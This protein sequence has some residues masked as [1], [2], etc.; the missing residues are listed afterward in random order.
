MIKLNA[1]FSSKQ[2]ISNCLEIKKNPD[3][4]FNI[5]N[6]MLINILGFHF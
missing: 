3:T 1:L 4:V 5:Y 6:F 2:S